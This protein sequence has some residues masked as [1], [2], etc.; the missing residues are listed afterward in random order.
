[1]SPEQVLGREL[2]SRTDLFSLGV[3]LYEMATRT[4]PFRGE[5]A[6]AT[7]DSI[8]HK[9]PAPPVRLNPD[10]P[11]EL[12]RI[13][14]K[15]LEKDRDLRYQS[16]SEVRADLMRL[17]RDTTSGTSVTP[18]QGE[19]SPRRWSWPAAGLGVAA[20]VGLALLLSRTAPPAS[21]GDTPTPTA[22]AAERQKLVV[23]PFE[24]L[25]A[26]EDAYFAAGMTEEITS[27]LAQVN[28]LGVISRTSAVQYD[29]TGKTARQIG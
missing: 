24:N 16:A 9:T 18:A 5:T 3:V 8:L 23:L 4:L 27:R 2:D 6:G 15:C 19:A 26:P 17:S 1:M 12:E 22:A 21:V 28:G 25:G 11:V 14:A 13:I 29:R 10:L 7:L 20:A